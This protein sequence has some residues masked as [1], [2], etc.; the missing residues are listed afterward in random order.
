MSIWINSLGLILLLGGCVAGEGGISTSSRATPILAGSVN[1]GVPPGYCVDPRASQVTEDS[2]VMIIGR[3]SDAAGVVPAAITATVGEAGS[4]AVLA[5]GVPA[6]SAYFASAEGRS[7]LSREGVA[8]AVAIQEI[9]ASDGVLILHLTD[10]A[11]GDYWRAVMAARGRLVTL[12]VTPPDGQPLS[13]DQGKALLDKAVRAMQ[14][15]NAAG[16]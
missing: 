2:A 13:P 9:R 3:C 12:A 16:G 5:A 1:L 10:R 6:L 8:E 15:A 4:A 7:A 14:S 11:M